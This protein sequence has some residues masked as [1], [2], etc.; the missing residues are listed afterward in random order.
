[1]G[2][3]REMSFGDTVVDRLTG[4]KGLVL[5]KAEYVDGTKT[6]L[7]QPHFA[8]DGVAAKE[9][10]IDTYRLD[11]VPKAK[12]RKPRKVTDERE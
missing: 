11:I 8:K 10:W 4:L 1:M 3:M 9:T 5:A 2:S 7:V 6:C 12:A